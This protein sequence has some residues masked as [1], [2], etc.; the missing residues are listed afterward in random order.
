M[1]GIVV[2]VVAIVALRDPKS[3]TSSDAAQTVTPSASADSSASSP[4][5]SPSRTSS[6]AS[7]PASKTA[8]SSSAASSTP[9]VSP[10]GS[11]SSAGTVDPK[12]IPLVVLNNTT[13]SGL[14]KRAA[15]RFEDGGWTVTS[16]GNL[17]NNIISTCAYY[18]PDTRGAKAAAMAL[19]AQ[20]PT[21]K[22]VEP[23]FSQLP[24]GPVVVVL[25]PGYSSG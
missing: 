11:G 20:F 19:Q 25:T 6:R 12:S 14:A 2:L 8:T 17:T 4:A 9:P 23:K 1:V 21:I 5:P 24:S 3:D 22:R 15:Q 16:S 13:I 10:S 7:S 18:D